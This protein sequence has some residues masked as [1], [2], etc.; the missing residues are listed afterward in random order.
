VLVAPRSEEGMMS[1]VRNGFSVGCAAVLVGCAGTVVELENWGQSSEALTE[2]SLLDLGLGSGSAAADLNGDGE[3][4]GYRRI[5]GRRN[6]IRWNDGVVTDIHPA[7]Y[8]GSQASVINS[9]GDAAGSLQVSD[10]VWHA[11]LWPVAL[12]GGVIDLDPDGT[13]ISQVH[14]LNDAM[15]AAGAGIHGGAFFWSES[16]GFVLIGNLGGGHLI[17]LGAMNESGYVV[18]RSTVGPSGP[19]HAWVAHDGV[20]TD[21]GTLGGAESGANDISDSLIVVGYAETADGHT[22]AVKWDNGVITD[23]DPTATEES[24]AVA[25]NDAGHVVGYRTIGGQLYATMWRDGE[26]IDLGA[27]PGSIAY[28]VN[29]LDLVIGNRDY[30]PYPQIAFAWTDETEGAV[31]LPPPAGKPTSFMTGLGT[32]TALGYGASFFFAPDSVAVSWSIEISPPPT[33]EAIGGLIDGVS[34][35]ET[36][37]ALSSGEAQSL[38]SK[39]E[40]ALKQ[41]ERGNANAATNQIE[42][43]IHHIEAFVQSGKLTAAEGAAL[44]NEAQA[45]LASLSC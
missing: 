21:L 37:G 12:G 3:I 14:F 6:A 41:C 33:D 36:G 35:L 7:N 31:D 45:I 29:E 39:L 15:Q 25:V 28:F 17:S 10:S 13:V 8:L 11:A 9:G 42:A 5:A 32:H 34:D 18:G 2:V 26:I 24:G 19:D 38:S 16:T 4:V 1:Q 23:L 30:A 22:H 40:G 27:G 20:T 44:I 43:F